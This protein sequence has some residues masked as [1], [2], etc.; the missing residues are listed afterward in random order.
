MNLQEQMKALFCEIVS[1]KT[2]RENIEDHQ[3]MV[4]LLA[5]HLNQCQMSYQ[6]I[7]IYDPDVI[8]YSVEEGITGES[9]DRLEIIDTNRQ[10]LFARPQEQ[11]KFLLY[12][13][14]DIVPA[15]GWDKAFQISQEAD[16]IYGR[17]TNDMKGGII[18]IIWALREY[19]EQYKRVPP[20]KVA[21]VPD[22]EDWSKA[23]WVLVEKYRNLFADIQAIIVPET[24]DKLGKQSKRTVTFLKGRRGRIQFN[25]RIKGLSCHG[26]IPNLGINP[27]YRIPDVL[28]VLK[29]IPLYYDDSMG[30]SDSLAVLSVKSTQS[31]LSIPYEVVLAVDIHYTEKRLIETG[32]LDPKTGRREPAAVIAQKLFRNLMP[33]LMRLNGVEFELLRRP[34]PFLPVWSQP[35]GSD[36]ILCKIRNIANS[37]LS[38]EI[39]ESVGNSVADENVLALLASEYGQQL[40][41]LDISPYGEN[42]HAID[43]W[44]SWDT[45]RATKDVFVRLMT[46]WQ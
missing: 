8:D 4:K 28:E 11:A 31:Q 17:G 5:S 7:P 30:T 45:L 10:I 21:F 27:I 15:M 46:E 9:R 29:E 14:Y 26:A 43:E 13:H 2:V 1:L 20:V 32:L 41:I 18:A 44:V 34:T 35:Q 22:E 39:E 33:F 19:F 38:Y 3:K 6:F 25:I 16:T 36:A 42:A 24:G 12:G 40:V 23:A 37:A